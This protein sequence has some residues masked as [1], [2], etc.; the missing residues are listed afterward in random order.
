MAAAG[1]DTLNI[2][3]GLLGG[4]NT[5]DLTDQSKNSGIFAGSKFTNFEAFTGVDA[6][7]GF[8]GASFVFR[9]TGLAE[10][11]TGSAL[12]DDLNPAAGNDIIDGGRGNDTLT[13]GKGKDHFLFD[14]LLNA[15][16]NVDTITD[17]SSKDTIELDGAIF[18]A[19]TKTG[20]LKN[21]FFHIGKKAHD[22]NDHIIYNAKNGALSY[23][24]DGKGG[25]A[26]IQF[27][28]LTHKPDLTHSDFLVA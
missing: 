28:T 14:T 7:G 4:A 9:G 16:T 24:A 1:T 21:S 20:T 10:G 27:A 6:T 26:Q 23:D 17:F 3:T 22:G 25:A 11:I 18:K 2:G 15:L 13:G 8:T 12:A 19:L 5:L